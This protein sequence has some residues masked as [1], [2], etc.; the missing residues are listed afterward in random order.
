MFRTA[1]AAELS[2]LRARRNL[3]RRKFLG[4]H[5]SQ[6]LCVPPRIR[7]LKN[8]QEPHRES[9]PGTQTIAPP[10]A[11]VVDNFFCTNIQLVVTL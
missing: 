10:L 5:F 2:A 3:H 1:R 8:F 9:N 11:A 7:S 6:R 4:I